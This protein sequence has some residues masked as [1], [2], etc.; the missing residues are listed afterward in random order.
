[1]TVMASLVLQACVTSQPQQVRQAPV[2][3]ASAL[4]KAPKPVPPFDPGAFAKLE[5]AQT[6]DAE[7]ARLSSEATSLESLAS[8][9]RDQADLPSTIESLSGSQDTR[10]T[11]R[12]LDL[13]AAKRARAA[14]LSGEAS[15][16]RKQ[17]DAE[18]PGISSLVGTGAGQ[19]LGEVLGSITANMDAS[20]GPAAAPEPEGPEPPPAPPDGTPSSA[21]H[22]PGTTNGPAGAPPVPLPSVRFAAESEKIDGLVQGSVAVSAPSSTK[23]GDSFSVYLRVSPEKLSAVMQALR[24]EF[25]ENLTVKGQAGIKLTPRMSASVSGFGFEVMPKDGQVQAISAREATTW[26][27]QVKANEPGVHTLTFTLSGTL[28]IEDKEVARNF[29]QYVQKVDVKVNPT[30][31]LEQYW[32]WLVTTLA[33]PAIGAVWAVYRKR[34]GGR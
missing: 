24:G 32:Q 14:Q 7:A 13:A 28:T 16:L 4:P 8:R 1:M 17:A 29:Y 18:V 6:L 5:R 30:G 26:A 21:S 33:I 12:L 31:L 15:E 11:A 22:L 25:P 10:G 19:T 3:S 2:Q 27:W 20:F 23:V 34:K 9:S